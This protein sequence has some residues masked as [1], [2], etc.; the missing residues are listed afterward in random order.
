MRR[1][2]VFLVLW[3]GAALAGD[4][5]S[6]SCRLSNGTVTGGGAVD[7]V[8]E[9]GSIR[10]VG[11]TIGDSRPLGVSTAGTAGPT[12][13]SGFWPAVSGA[14]DSDLDGVGDAVDNCTLVPNPLQQDADADGFGNLCDTDL[15]NS[16]LSNLIDL[17]LFRQVFL[18]ADAEADFNSDGFANLP[19][20]AILR[21]RF[22]ESRQ[23]V[24][25]G[26]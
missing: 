6:A 7:L 20:F 10:A 8:S 15:D 13:A 18:S 21:A 23:P 1:L 24:A 2:A 19:D 17:W 22:G 12:L 14:E 9:S 11:T 5:P 26:G 16:G 4:L 3:S 25:S